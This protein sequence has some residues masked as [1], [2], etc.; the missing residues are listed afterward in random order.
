[1]LKREAKFT[2]LF[3]TWVKKEYKNTGAFEIK[4]TRGKNYLPFSEVKPHQLRA[5]RITKHGFFAY[6]ISDAAIGYKPFDC[7]S[8]A[9]MP[10]YIVISYPEFFC[11]IDI[12]TFEQIMILSA[13]ENVKSLDSET[14][15]EYSKFIILNKKKGA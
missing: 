2:T 1:M 9:F 3:L 12:D 7:F 8:M 14:A 6:K 11:L 15:K 13:R 10:A 4:S 5:L